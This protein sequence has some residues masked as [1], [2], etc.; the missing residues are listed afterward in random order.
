MLSRGYSGTLPGLR[1]TT[2]SIGKWLVAASLPVVAWG[3]A[4]AAWMLR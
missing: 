2:A 4:V 3:V 1:T